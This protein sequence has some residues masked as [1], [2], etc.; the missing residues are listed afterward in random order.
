MRQVVEFLEQ[1]GLKIGP[2]TLGLAA[3]ALFVVGATYGLMKIKNMEGGI[4]NGIKI[5]ANCS[6]CRPFWMAFG[7]GIIGTVLVAR[8]ATIITSGDKS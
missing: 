7:V 6:F 1:I 2:T 4:L 5:G 3:G 8:A